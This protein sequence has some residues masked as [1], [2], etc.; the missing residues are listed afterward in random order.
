MWR[1]SDGGLHA[2]LQKTK[3]H[4][5]TTSEID[6]AETTGANVNTFTPDV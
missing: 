4:V 5:K 3:A 6:T 1:E 2:S